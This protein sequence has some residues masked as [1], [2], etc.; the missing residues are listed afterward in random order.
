MNEPTTFFGMELMSD[1][2]W[3]LIVR[4][5]INFFF[6]TGIIRY[7]YYRKTPRK[8]YLFTFYMISV[9]SFLICFALKKFEM[10]VGMGLG[11]FAIFGIIR[12]RTNP[13]RIR[14]MTYL[15]L[16]IGLSVINALSNK[17]SYA[18]VFFINGIVWFIIYVMENWWLQSNEAD[19]T[20]IYEKIENIKPDNYELLIADLENRTGLKIN[21][22]V[23]GKIDFL[24][25]TAEIKI[26][27]DDNSDNE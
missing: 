22:A 8:S 11:L 24:K 15:F 17:L 27:F 23:V 20:I 14:E 7:V 12:Y 13:M 21:R 18:E 26:Y 3:K 16:V 6:L 1:D 2:L 9:I 5:L 10:E 4:F 19:K 25:D